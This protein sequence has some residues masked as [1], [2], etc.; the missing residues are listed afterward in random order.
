MPGVWVLAQEARPPYRI[1]YVPSDYLDKTNRKP[2]RLVR[3][4]SIH[5][6]A[7]T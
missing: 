3:S 5:P 6:L 2:I 7:L 4:I 1:G